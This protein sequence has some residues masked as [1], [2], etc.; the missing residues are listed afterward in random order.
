[1]AYWQ[2]LIRL[3]EVAMPA[4]RF[5][6]PL[7]TAEET[8]LQ[9]RYRTTSDADERSRCQ[10]I[11][12]SARG[13][14]VPEIADLTLFDDDTVLA[15]ARS[16]RSGWDRWLDNQTAIREATQKSIH[17]IKTRLSRRWILH[18]VMSASR[19]RP[20]RAL[21]WRSIWRSRAMSQ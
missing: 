4:P 1:M 14:T 17:P 5:I 16:L 3:H 12:F 6:R 21:T 11:L 2:Q 15:L 20:G 7:T 9:E 19:S 18:H 10:M 13:K 8:A